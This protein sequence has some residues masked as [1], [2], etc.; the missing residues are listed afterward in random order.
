MWSLLSR[1]RVVG[2]SKSGGRPNP[3]I[4]LSRKKGFANLDVLNKMTMKGML[5]GKT[6]LKHVY[7]NEKE[8]HALF[9]L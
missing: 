3:V 2:V 6:R 4:P 7:F 1:Q 5:L 9:F 8:P